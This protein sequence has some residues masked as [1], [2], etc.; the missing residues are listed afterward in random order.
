MVSSTVEQKEKVEGV[1]TEMCHW[2]DRPMTL[3]LRDNLS[4][5]YETHTLS[6]L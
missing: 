4:R 5:W 1:G 6:I 3:C 2:K